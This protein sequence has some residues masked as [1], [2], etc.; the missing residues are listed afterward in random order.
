MTIIYC[1]FLSCHTRQKS[2]IP[3][4]IIHYS[5]AN[6]PAI[7]LK[8]ILIRNHSFSTN[9]NF[10]EKPT[11]LS[12][13]YAHA[14]F[15]KFYVL[16]KWRDDPFKEKFNFNCLAQAFRS[17]MLHWFTLED[18]A[19]IYASLMFDYCKSWCLLQEKW[20]H[21][22][23]I[24]LFRTYINLNSLWCICTW[25]VC[26]RLDHFWSDVPI[27]FQIKTWIFCNLTFKV[28]RSVHIAKRTYWLY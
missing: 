5:K 3:K 6:S 22:Q 14:N 9:T 24:K 7:I 2:F 21:N 8:V 4:E 27:F 17:K 19:K 28:N 18:R 15:R 23:N 20:F 10:S 13:W 12:P 1:V 25:S 11:L 26:E 16:T